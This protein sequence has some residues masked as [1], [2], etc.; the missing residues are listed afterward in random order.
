VI[1]ALEWKNNNLNKYAD[2]DDLDSSDIMEILLKY[3]NAN[4]YKHRKNVDEWKK[5]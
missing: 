5:Q 2:L 4:G 1:A 3:R